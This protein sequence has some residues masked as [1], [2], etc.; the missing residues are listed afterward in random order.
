MN[1]REVFEFVKKYMGVVHITD[2]VSQLVDI[3]KPIHGVGLT[4][5][6]KYLPQAEINPGR[7]TKVY[8][9]V[10]ISTSALEGFKRLHS[11]D[12]ALV[13]AMLPD[14]KYDETGTCESTLI[15]SVN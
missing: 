8:T 4:N 7:Y 2:V 11:N 6:L 9:P 3:L 14:L 15:K 12:L 5:F 1:A 13:H 10:D